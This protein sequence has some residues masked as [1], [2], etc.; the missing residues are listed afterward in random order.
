MPWEHCGQTVPDDAPCPACATSKEQWTLEFDVTRTFKVSRRASVR[1]AL[2]D[3][4]GEPVAGEPYEVELPGGQL[5]TGELD[6]LGQATVPMSNDGSFLVS[7]PLRHQLAVVPAPEEG[8]PPQ[9]IHAVDA[10]ED[11][12]EPQD[13][14]AVDAEEEEEVPEHA[15]A[16]FEREGAHRHR[17]RLA[18]DCLAEAEGAEEGEAHDLKLSLVDAEG[19]PRAS[20]PYRVEWPDGHR[21]EGRLD[22]EGLATVPARSGTP[23]V[24]FP[25]RFPHEVRART[26][27]T[28]ERWET[29]HVHRFVEDED[30]DDDDNAVVDDPGGGGASSDAG[31]DEGNAETVGHGDEAPHDPDEVMA[32]FD[33]PPS[34][35]THELELDDDHCFAAGDEEDEEEDAEFVCEAEGRVVVHED[36]RRAI[37]EAR[38]LAGEPL[39]VT[40]G[41]C[42]TP[43]AVCP[44][45][46]H[47]RHASGDAAHVTN[48]DTLFYIRAAELAGLW[49]LD[50][51]GET[52][53]DRTDR[54]RAKAIQANSAG[55]ASD[56]IYPLGVR[57][58]PA[59]A[60]WSELSF[61]ALRDGTRTRQIHLHRGEDPRRVLSIVDGATWR[62]LPIEAARLGQDL[63]ILHKNKWWLASFHRQWG[64]E[65]VIA[66][67]LGLCR[68]YKDRMGRLL[69]VGDVSHV[70]GEIQTDHGSHRLGQDVDVYV[71]LDGADGYPD[72]YWCDSTD[73]DDI[74]RLPRPSAPPSETNRT[75]EY[76]SGERAVAID[77]A[78]RAEVLRGYATILAY[79]MVTRVQVDLVIWRCIRNRALHDQA[80]TIASEAFAAGWRDEWGRVNPW[81][82]AVNPWVAT[83][84]EQIGNPHQRLDHGNSSSPVDDHADHC[85]IRIYPEPRTAR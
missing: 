37:R 56:A 52:D 65:H 63:Y 23:V 78:T 67:I 5:V 81:T 34:A 74:A 8:E 2:E 45:D 4:A 64:H 27:R 69:G 71:L 3:P 24:R 58:V 59:A 84:A 32:S 10:A 70:V 1:L 26:E 14:H 9:D 19:A 57:Q 20:E 44:A 79:C 60:P 38:T 11:P 61:V 66:W 31:G 75:P 21:D 7:F 42:P 49:G 6:E 12:A 62:S 48:L 33:C 73:P 28:T 53:T 83:N 29:V 43:P 72:S 40:G 25:R 76:G 35:E 22:E 55:V 80:E 36:V 85:H 39:P 77:D 16:T 17:F 82:G 18:D 54:L 50:L 46:L 13:I 51:S 41:V 15:A 68:F 47:D 30:D